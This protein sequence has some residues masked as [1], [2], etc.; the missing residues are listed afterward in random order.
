MI[1][2]QSSGRPIRPRPTLSA[3][4][5]YRFAGYACAVL[6]SAA[7]HVGASESVP[8]ASPVV[9]DIVGQRI[10]VDRGEALRLRDTAATLA[11]CSSAAR[12]LSLLLDRALHR[13]RVLALRRTEAHTLARLAGDIGLTALA[14]EITACTT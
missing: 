10:E 14:T 2:P 13:S 8:G 12:D 3:V 1:E 4:V 9:L 6:G 11:G 5:S 7:L